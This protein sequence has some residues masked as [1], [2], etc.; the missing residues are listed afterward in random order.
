MGIRRL[1]FFKNKVTTNIKVLWSVSGRT[2]RN[3]G[4]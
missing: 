4:K 2:H 1:K 3:G